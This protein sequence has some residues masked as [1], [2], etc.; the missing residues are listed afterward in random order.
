MP[1]RRSPLACALTR[2]GRYGRSAPAW[3]D[4]LSEMPP[5]LDLRGVDGFP[6]FIR[7]RA[8]RQQGTACRNGEDVHARDRVRGAGISHSPKGFLARTV[9]RVANDPRGPATQ[10]CSVGD[11]VLHQATVSRTVLGASLF[12]AIVQIE[13]EPPV[14]GG[15]DHEGRMLAMVTVEA[16]IAAVH[17]AGQTLISGGSCRTTTQAIVPLR[18]RPRFD[19]ER[20]G[21]LVGRYHRPPFTGCGWITPLVNLLVAGP[22]NAVVIDLIPLTFFREIALRLTSAPSRRGRGHRRGGTPSSSSRMRQGRT[23]PRDAHY[24]RYPVVGLEAGGIRPNPKPQVGPVAATVRSL[25]PPGNKSATILGRDYL[26]PRCRTW[27]TP[28]RPARLGKRLQTAW[29]AAIAARRPPLGISAPA[30]DGPPAG[31]SGRRTKLGPAEPDGTA[32]VTRR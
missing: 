28:L 11:L 25:S 7:A 6:A 26:S 29:T 4:L 30:G 17:A 27:L 21:R 16:V 2:G 22:G 9:E 13:A 19:L 23:A 14:I 1:G 18:S 5:G 31:T 8:E 10:V 12:S 24:P 32:Q 15:V 20:G 3:R